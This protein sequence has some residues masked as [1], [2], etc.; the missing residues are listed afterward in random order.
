MPQRLVS[1]SASATT[2]ASAAG[3]PVAHRHAAAHSA[4]CAWGTRVMPVAVEAS[5][6]RPRHHALL[7]LA[8]A[9]DAERNPVARLQVALRLLAHAHPRRR[10]GG[11]D[12]ARQQ[13]H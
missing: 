2:C 10:A 4:T 7:L 3:T 9:G 1:T 12:V 13:S 11:D 6:R 8:Q 5:A